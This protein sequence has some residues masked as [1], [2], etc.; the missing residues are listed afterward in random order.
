[1]GSHETVGEHSC[2]TLGVGACGSGD[3]RVSGLG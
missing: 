2:K 3:T 1:M